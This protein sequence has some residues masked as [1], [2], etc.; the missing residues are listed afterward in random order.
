MR[1]PNSVITLN[2]NKNTT[3]SNNDSVH[4]IL[5]IKR[6][7]KI[8]LKNN[9]NLKRVDIFGDVDVSCKIRDDIEYLDAYKCDVDC[10]SKKLINI[11]L[12][13]CTSEFS[14]EHME[15]LEHLN[16]HNSEGLSDIIAPNLISL[17]V[18]DSEFNFDQSFNNLVSLDIED[19]NEED[20]LSDMTREKFPVLQSISISGD[21]T[22]D[23][24]KDIRDLHCYSIQT[25]LHHLESLEMNIIESLEE[26]NNI[27][28]DIRTIKIGNIFGD[29][30]MSSYD[31]GRFKN[32]TSLI[33]EENY[34]DIRFSSIMNNLIYL[35]LN[36]SHIV[37]LP[38]A[39]HLKVLN[40][41][42]ITLENKV[43]IRYDE[44]RIF[45]TDKREEYKVSLNS[46]IIVK[47][48]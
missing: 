29:D 18:R 1:N 33:I 17:T 19:E 14:E 37:S 46:N 34:A 47:D 26:F 11:S 25:K 42:D 22:E 44:L 43:P 21:Y 27:S 8:T 3:I 9:R 20:I 35:E 45:I 38:A 4:M 40:L 41:H 6:G 2:I 12:S 10:T 39:P 16:L 28:D 36:T 7:K 5:R 13:S 48:H 30:D 24:L 23:Y 31:F 15:Y 32:L